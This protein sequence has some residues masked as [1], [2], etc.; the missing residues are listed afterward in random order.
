MFYS[1]ELC[2]VTTEQS[3]NIS[4]IGPIRV[5]CIAEQSFLYLL[6]YW[7]AGEGVD[8]PE[9]ADNLFWES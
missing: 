1:A 8:F 6:L 9:G 4:D 5:Q 2:S 3:T 7:L